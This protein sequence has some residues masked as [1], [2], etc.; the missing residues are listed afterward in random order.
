MGSV[1]VSGGTGYMG[2]ALVE[3]LVERGHTVRV[4][5]RPGSERKVP[6]GT[7]VV[8]GNALDALTFSGGVAPAS[9]YVHLT[10]AA[11][12]APWKERQF[13]AIDLA[14]LRA[15]V[16]AA[17]S[18]SISHFIYVSVAHPAPVMKAYIRVRSECESILQNEN[19]KFGSTI[20][21]P[22]YVLGPGHWWPV[23]LKP[24]Y[25]LLESRPSTR[26]GALRLGLVTLAQM[27]AALTWAVENPH[28]AT[29]ILEVPEIRKRQPDGTLPLTWYEHPYRSS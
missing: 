1:F 5:T 4:L 26:E 15:S 17:T 18:A 23:A 24:I 9:T 2:R 12:P 8:P 19:T 13:Q 27:V 16:C 29:R 10:G 3:Q 22:W 6:L 21:R 20:L 11:H 14:S 7:T 28:S 25:A